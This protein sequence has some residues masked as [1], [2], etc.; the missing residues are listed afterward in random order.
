MNTSPPVAA[1][2]ILLVDD[3]ATVRMLIES[4]LID[5]GYKV[6]TMAQRH[7]NT[8]PPVTSIAW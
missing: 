8:S 2:C 7:W 6:L 5:A 1:G 4:V 3:D